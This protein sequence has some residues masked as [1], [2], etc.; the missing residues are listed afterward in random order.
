MRN[1]R[2]ENNLF[3]NP[4][5]DMIHVTFGRILFAEYQFCII[6]NMSFQ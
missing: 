3:K 4:M 5:I 2:Q 1:P 6:I